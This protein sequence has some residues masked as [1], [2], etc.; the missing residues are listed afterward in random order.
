MSASF[1]VKT[2]GKQQ[3]VTMGHHRLQREA[4]LGRRPDETRNKSAFRR[5]S[6]RNAVVA[7]DTPKAVVEAISASG[8]SES[9]PYTHYANIGKKWALS[10]EAFSVTVFS[11]GLPN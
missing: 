6:R 9:Q 10:A 3:K 1:G 7:D 4:L 5:K 2:P 11:S 8:K